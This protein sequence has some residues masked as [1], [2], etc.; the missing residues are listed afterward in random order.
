MRGAWPAWDNVATRGDR[1]ALRYAPSTDRI[2]GLR[3]SAG[4]RSA[5]MAD[6]HARAWQVIAARADPHEAQRFR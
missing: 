5:H 2:G 6:A 1:L 4:S 3:K